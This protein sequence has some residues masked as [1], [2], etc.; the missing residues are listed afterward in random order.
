MC[1]NAWEESQRIAEES[2]AEFYEI[3]KRMRNWSLARSILI[4]AA[5]QAVFILLAQFVLSFFP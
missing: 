3:A 2:E 5:T 4:V 1:E